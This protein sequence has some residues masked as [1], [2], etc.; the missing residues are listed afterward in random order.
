MSCFINVSHQFQSECQVILLQ[1]SGEN[2]VLQAILDDPAKE[3]GTVVSKTEL[4][5]KEKVSLFDANFFYFN[6]F[7]TGGMF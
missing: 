1:H 2:L 6:I 4:L 3:N 7:S 5:N